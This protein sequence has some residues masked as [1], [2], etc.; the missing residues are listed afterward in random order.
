VTG[1]IDHDY[2]D[3]D[4]GH[5]NVALLSPTRLSKHRS[6]LLDRVEDQNVENNE[7]NEENQTEKNRNYG[8]NL[9]KGES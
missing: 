3:E 7:E 4:C 8:R 2:E 1:P 9:K 6:F 5:K